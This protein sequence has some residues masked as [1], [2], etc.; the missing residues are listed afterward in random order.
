MAHAYLKKQETNIILQN[1]IDNSYALDNKS[2]SLY[3]SKQVMVQDV[4]SHL[5]S[6]I[7]PKVRAHISNVHSITPLERYIFEGKIAVNGV[8]RVMVSV[9]GWRLELCPTYP[10]ISLPISTHISLYRNFQY[11]RFCWYV[12]YCHYTRTTEIQS[13]I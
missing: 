2:T 11:H 6:I 5:V 8:N 13:S 9:C 3:A 12:F 4:M 1:L 10:S 7:H